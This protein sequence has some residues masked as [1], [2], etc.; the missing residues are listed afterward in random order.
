MDALVRFF[1]FV[2]ALSAL[3]VLMMGC[4]A[5]VPVND[6]ISVS[7]TGDYPSSQPS[8]PECAD[9]SDCRIG[10]C[11]RT[12][13]HAKSDDPIV[14]TCEWREE[15]SCYQQAACVCMGGKCGWKGD[16]AFDSCIIGARTNKQAG[17]DVV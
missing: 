11:S 10:G 9:D 8:S 5:R 4:A 16:S 12:V 6:M 7:P 15:Y 14:T 3:S 17:K 1:L 2:I 13:C